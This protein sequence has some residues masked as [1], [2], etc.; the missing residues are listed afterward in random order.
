[1]ADIDPISN[2]PISHAIFVLLPDIVGDRWSFTVTL[3]HARHVVHQLY[4][5]RHTENT[6]WQTPVLNSAPKTYAWLGCLTFNQNALNSFSLRNLAQTVHD[7]NEKR[8]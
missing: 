1:M 2:F 6:T 8:E 5:K 4:R 3:N 7:N